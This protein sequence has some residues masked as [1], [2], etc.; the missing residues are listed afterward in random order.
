MKKYNFFQ[1]LKA[2]FMGV[3]VEWL[4]SSEVEKMVMRYN[5]LSESEKTEFLK[6]IQNGKK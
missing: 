6:M 2:S 4:Y 3:N 5:H 1:V